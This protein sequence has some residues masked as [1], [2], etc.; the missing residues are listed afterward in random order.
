MEYYKVEL[1]KVIPTSSGTALILETEVKTFLMVIGL[2]EGAAII[3]ELNKTKPPRPLTHE[4]I[5]NILTGF[6]IQMKQVVITD[7][8]DGAFIATLVLEQVIQDE[9]GKTFRQEVRI[10]ARPSDCIILALKYNKEVYVTKQVLDKV[11]DIR[12]EIFL[13]EGS[14]GEEEKEFDWKDL[15]FGSDYDS[16]KPDLFDED[17]GKE[18]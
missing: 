6:D 7:I 13:A 15:S 18:D 10:D 16:G 17:E 12:K 2:Y 8:I 9:K 5:V 14:E 11:N 3:R 4:L 1:K